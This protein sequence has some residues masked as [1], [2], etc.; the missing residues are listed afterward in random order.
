MP[1][2][3]DLDI[4]GKLYSHASCDTR[5][6]GL[7]MKGMKEFAWKT[8]VDT[9]AGRG[10]AREDLGHTEGTV[11]YEASCTVLSAYWDAIKEDSRAKGFAPLDRPGLFSITITAPGK[12]TKKIEVRFSRISESDASS[13]DSPD[14]HEVK[15][16]FKVL[17]NLEDGR[18]LIANSLYSKGVI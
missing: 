1:L 16:T 18:P 13:S 15:L 9:G 17:V 6:Y 3:P 8:T 10:T 14:A 2:P 12:A 5:I 11:A 4:N 7:R